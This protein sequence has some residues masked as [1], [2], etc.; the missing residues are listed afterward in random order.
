MASATQTRVGAGFLSYSKTQSANDQCVD[1]QCPPPAHGDLDTA[2]TFAVVSNVGFIVAGAGAATTL[3]GI[4]MSGGRG[5]AKP[6]VHA[7]A[8]PYVGPGQ[9]GLTGAF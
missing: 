3:L 7:H 1:K 5:E 2:T 9:L 6:A 4:L 8:E